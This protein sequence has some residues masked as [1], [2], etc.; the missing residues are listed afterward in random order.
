MVLYKK[1]KSEHLNFYKQP[2]TWLSVGFIP[3]S[4]KRTPPPPNPTHPKSQEQRARC[5]HTYKKNASVTDSWNIYLVT[6]EFNMLT[7]PSK[8]YIDIFYDDI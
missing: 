4:P 5:T 2:A 1:K 8:I 7:L 6:K 3:S